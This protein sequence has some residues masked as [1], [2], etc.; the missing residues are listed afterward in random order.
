MTDMPAQA[1]HG[2]RAGI[3][4]PAK[5][6]HHRTLTVLALLALAGC[7]STPANHHRHTSQH[8]ASAQ[9]RYCVAG[10]GCYRVLKSAKG[11]RAHGIASWYGRGDTGR[12]TASGEPYDPRAMR[13][14]SKELPFGTWV[15]IRN[16][17]NGREAVAMVDDRGPFHRGRIIDASVAVARRLAMIRRGTA[18]VRVSAIASGE[19]SKAQREAARADQRR[20]VRYARAHPHGQIMAEAGHVAVRGV[21]DVTSLGVD[22]GVGVVKGSVGLGFDILKT[23]L[24]LVF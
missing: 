13:I 23:T 1:R 20:A 5:G 10:H 7:A 22:I 11:Y 3:A 24:G 4:G 6:N 15:R 12:P 8:A 9:A 19:L 2:P 16:L 14:A 17:R 21:V 18:P